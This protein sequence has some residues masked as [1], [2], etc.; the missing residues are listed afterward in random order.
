MD[1][2]GKYYQILKNLKVQDREKKQWKISVTKPSIIPA[3]MYPLHIKKNNVTI[4]GLKF[5]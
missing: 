3:F 4:F 1:F 2:Y 5:N